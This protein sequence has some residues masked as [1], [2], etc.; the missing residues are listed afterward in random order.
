VLS[1]QAHTLPCT[2]AAGRELVQGIAA[3]RRVLKT[4]V[5]RLCCDLSVMGAWCGLRTKGCVVFCGGKA[6]E[7]ERRLA[8]RRG[9]GQQVRRLCPSLSSLSIFPL[10]TPHTGPQSPLSYLSTRRWWTR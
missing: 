2:L 1:Q 9:S 5:S 4:M 6:E 3:E 10:S 8:E 7:D